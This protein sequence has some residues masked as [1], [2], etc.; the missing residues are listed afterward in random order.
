MKVTCPARPKSVRMHKTES[1]LVA[2][3]LSAQEPWAPGRPLGRPTGP[4]GHRDRDAGGRPRR[5]PGSESFKLLKLLR[6]AR[7]RPGSDLKPGQSSESQP[8]TSLSRPLPAR[9]RHWPSLT[10]EACHGNVTRTA[11]G[12]GCTVTGSILSRGVTRARP[13]SWVTVGCRRRGPESHRVPI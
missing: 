1:A 10:R 5:G 13:V 3:V 11:P 6:M 8:P 9:G 7:D 4:R 12:I 2:V